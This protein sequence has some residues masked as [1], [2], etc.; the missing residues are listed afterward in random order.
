MTWS[1]RENM[2]A[3]LERLKTQYSS[4]HGSD[5]PALA[6]LKISGKSAG[7]LRLFSTHPDLDDRIQRLRAI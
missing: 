6:T 1:G 3:A 5:Q 7:F 2:V 4:A